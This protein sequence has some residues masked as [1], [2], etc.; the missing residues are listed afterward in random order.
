MDVPLDLSLLAWMPPLVVGLVEL[1][2]RTRVLADRNRVW[3]LASLLGGLVVTCLWLCYSPPPLAGLQFVGW[4]GLHG[5]AVGLIAC[6]EY[7]L[8]ARPA[9]VAAAKV[10][11]K[12]SAG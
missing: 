11:E 7:S 4:L 12:L 5:L 8:A 10:A 9:F 3:P 6:G 2:K 1:L